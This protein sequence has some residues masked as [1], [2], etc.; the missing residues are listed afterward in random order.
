MPKPSLATKLRRLR[1]AAGLSLRSLAGYSGVDVSV[2]SRI[3]AGAI[4]YP[5]TETLNRLATTLEVD[6]E[7]LY[8]AVWREPSSKHALPSMPLYLRSKYRLNA[9]EIAEVEASIKKI[10]ERNTK[11]KRM[12]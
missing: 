3:E 9:E 8:D 12:N 5:T 2:I 1:E 7:E 6:P 4:R 10:T 11:K